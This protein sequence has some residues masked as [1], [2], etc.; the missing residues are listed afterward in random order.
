MWLRL[1]CNMHDVPCFH[2]RTHID[3]VVYIILSAL[4]V[5]V[6]TDWPLNYVGIENKEHYEAYLKALQ[7]GLNLTLSYMKFLFFGPPRSGKTTTR[8]RLLREFVNLSQLNKP[9]LS[10]GVAETNDVIIKKFTNEPAAIASSQWWSMK[11]N[12]ERTQ[13]DTYMHREE[14]L[15]YLAQLFYQL[16]NT[17]KTATSSTSNES[18]P[19]QARSNPLELSTSSMG[20]QDEAKLGK[21][22]TESEEV[23]IKNAFEKLTSILKSDSPE[24]L[25]QL[26]K[27]LIMIN[28]M[29]VGGQPAFLDMLP[30]L[31]TGPALYLLFFRLDQEL[32]TYYPVRYLPADSKDELTLESSY[33]TEEVLF[34]SLAS[35]A[36]FSCHSLSSKPQASSGAESATKRQVLRSAESAAKR[37]V[38]RSAGSSNEPQASR[39]AESAAKRRVLRSAES[40]AKRRVLRSTE[41]AAKRQV[42]RSAGS[43]NVPQASRSA[44]SAAKRRVLR[45]AESA[46][47]R[48]V[49]RSAESAAKRRVLSA[50]SAAKRQVLRS[51]GSSNEPQ[52]SRSAESAAKRRVLRSAES[53]A[54]R[55]VLRSAES[56]A[57]RQVLRSAGSSNE[58][59]ASRS[60][61]SAAKRRVLRSVES[62]AK[63]GVLR[64]VESAA[65]RGVL[66]SAGSTNKQQTSRSAESAAK[67]G[68]LRSAG[69]SNKQQA[70][71]TAESVTKGRASRS[72]ESASKGQASKGQAS[73]ST[74]SVSKPQASSSD[75]SASKSQSSSRALLFGTYKDKVGD[76]QI[77]KMEST[78]QDKFTETKLYKEG[79]LMKSSKGKMMFTVDNMFGTDESEMSGIRKD[80]EEIIKTNFPAVPIPAAWLMFRI[81][82]NL[83]NKPVVSVTQCEEIAKKLSMHTPVQEALW[84]FHHNIGS[85]MHYPN[86]PSMKDT[87]ICDPQVI[88]DC[89]S[90]L[91]ID[92]FKYN[93][94]ALKSC[95]VDEFLQKG[96][97]TLSHIADKTSDLQGS[98]LTLDQLMDL[99]KHHNVVAE[100]IHDQ[101]NFNSSQ[102]E[103]DREELNSSQSEPKFIMPAILKVAS[104]EEL[105]TAVTTSPS[106]QPI[107]PIVIYFEGGFVPFGVFC[108]SVAHLIAHQ[109]SMSPKWQLCNDQVKRNKITFCIDSAF[110]VNITSRPQYL[111]IFV[112]RHSGARSKRSLPEICSTIRQTVVETLK[113]VISKMRYKPY[114]M[115]ETPL[116]SSIEQPFDL[117][118]TCC[119]D[120][121][122]GDHLMKV[123]EDEDE[124]YAK[125]LE[126]K[127]D[128]DLKGE[129]HIWFGQVSY[130]VQGRGTYSFI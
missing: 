91:I 18:V 85:L 79:L 38:L 127:I 32:K 61:E 97:F 59:Q 115:I 109:D 35:I 108:T 106:D 107:A 46:T 6:L 47:K 111:K 42:L 75:E 58:P 7:D 124:W 66:R 56:A 29:D 22:L 90:S 116:F 14:D 71:R 34:Q 39:S 27:D 92:K 68:V 8:R 117:A 26:L 83:L 52:A 53:A 86:I 45:S 60:A 67:R 23:E 11:R 3:W 4:R 129:H 113:T 28:M 57:K 121:S 98:H 49:L 40:A 78:L 118:F 101:E 41:S 31:T 69:S 123:V 30:A 112:S 110:Y 80:I 72:A 95:Q 76:N 1:Q 13:P 70:S 103:R 54:K 94:R 15:G 43:S 84:F 96:Q 88:Y 77:S 25:K 44:E 74:G 105:N 82:L 10:T 102:L 128:M 17:Y 73:K 64:S 48:R 125:C 55:R 89:I 33:S 65:K 9:T 99:L 36:C 100:I 81:V 12:K 50:E 20:T 104:D 19:V 130:R 122:H 21:K 87:V 37:Q 120:Y 126:K 62:A 114:A 2:I 5:H 24:E 51:A 63:R 16:I 93:N 119:L